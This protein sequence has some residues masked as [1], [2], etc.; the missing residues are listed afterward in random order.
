MFSETGLNRFS[1][2]FQVNFGF[3]ASFTLDFKLQNHV[4]INCF[5][6]RDYS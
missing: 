2:G 6:T 3:D 1:V 4:I 5:I